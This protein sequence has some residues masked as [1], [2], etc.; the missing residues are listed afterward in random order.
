MKRFQELSEQHWK[1]LLV[2]VFPIISLGMHLHLFNLPLQGIHA[3][4]QCETASN[5]IQFAEGDP[6]ILNP[7]VFSLEWPDGLK[8]MEFPL[9]QWLI[10]MIVKVVGHEI[11]VMRLFSWLIGY[12]SVLGIFVLFWQLFR[13]RWMAIVGAWA[14]MFSPVIFYYSINPLPDNMAL[15]A[16]VWGLVGTMAWIRNG[17]WTALLWAFAAFSLATAVKLPFVVL[18]AAPFGALLQLLIAKR[19]ENWGKI[20]GSGLLGLLILGPSLYWYA[21]V[22]PQWTGNGV[23]KGIFDTTTDEIPILIKTIGKNLL[24]ILPELLINYAATGFFVWGIWQIWRKKLYLHPLA[25][26]F[27]LMMA[28]VGFYFFYEINMISSVH[29]YYLFPFLPGI[30]ILV[31]IGFQDLA[32]QTKSWIRTLAMVLLLVLPVTAGLRAYTRWSLKGMPSDLVAHAADLRAATPMD[33]KIIAAHDLSPHIS[34]FHLRHFGWTF[35]A[36]GMEVQRFDNEVAAGAQFLYS[37]SRPMEADP[38]IATHLGK[39]IGQWG[40]YRVWKLK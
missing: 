9:M 14:W 2:L 27:G 4:R 11:L 3:W 7:H 37:N 23:I 22:I 38:R 31:G 8:R 32:G 29:D 1:L 39:L 28:G 19:G 15:M 34:L 20:V 6:N 40:E 16:S 36:Q 17:S 21:W 33:A 26:P 5:V 13:S 24:S 12:V 18:T 35:D 25:L 30:F 10:G